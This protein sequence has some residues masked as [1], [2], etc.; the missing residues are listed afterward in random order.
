MQLATPRSTDAAA[1]LRE[2]TAHALDAVVTMDV[3][4]AITGWNGRA[5]QL[6]GWPA[7]DVLGRPMHEVIIPERYRAA[8]RNGLAR[9]LLTGRSNILDKPTEISAL[10]R[11]GH[12][13]TVELSVSALAES[14]GT[15]FVGYVRDLTEQRRT[16]DALWESEVRFAGVIDN[17]PGVAYINRL[18]G[19]AE[20]VSPKI[21]EI[22]G[23]TPEAWIADDGLWDRS[24]LPEDRDRAREQIRAGAASGKP[25]SSIYRLRAADGRHVWIRDRAVVRRDGSGVE[26]VHGVMFDITRER[27]AEAQLELALAEQV[28]ITESLQ[29]LA[30]ARPEDLATGICRELRRT[31]HLDLAAVYEFRHDGSVV[32]IGQSVPADSP[33]RLHQPLPD[34]WAK[35]LRESATGP[36]ID[37]WPQRTS[38]D[39]F[40]QAWLDLGVTCAAFVPFGR[41]NETHGLLVAGTTSAIGSAGVA[42]WLPSLTQFAAAGAAL[43]VQELGAR[44]R[45]ED[46]R[47]RILA[48]ATEDAMSPVFQPIVSFES[49]ETLGFEALT[50]FRDGIPP[51]QRFAEAE[52]CGMGGALERAAVE[53]AFREARSLPRHAWIGVNV[54]PQRLFEQETLDLLATADRRVVVEI[55]ERSPIEDYD[56]IRVALAR[57]GATV[58]V[59][60]D[61]AGAGFASLRHILE[62]HPRYVKLDMQLVRGVDGDPV[63]QALIAGMVHFARQAGC[64]LIAEGIETDA[65]RRSVAM[66][67][68]SLAQ[69]YLFGVPSPA[70]RWSG[71][72]G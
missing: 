27:D 57:L 40:L 30:D 71:R 24:L 2:L 31:E 43:L 48:I 4:G 64:I 6:F 59:A 55:T 18:G 12:E 5:E 17:L 26:H 1:A 7:S 45:D 33:I 38:D 29:R 21:E 28:A 61:D 66:L 46:A 63:R 37:E 41:E 25:F 67:G 16:A 13:I 72:H 70:E 68:V 65:E 23:Y 60:V 39:P 9:Y 20:F 11:D 58:D 10:H 34:H 14:D 54:S 42:R 62:L 52:A 69:G 19:G 3:G 49:G 53:A 35:Y 36:W 47:A 15:T 22:L 50:R 51:D 56:Q 8:H 44:R 32:P